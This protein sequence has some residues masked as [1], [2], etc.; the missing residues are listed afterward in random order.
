MG[1]E[2]PARLVHKGESIR[3][4]TYE[5]N[6]QDARASRAI[7]TELVRG[8]RAFVGNRLGIQ[9]PSEIDREKIVRI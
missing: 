9:Q 4:R 5:E 2:V 1:I 3:D 7:A 6:G 8:Q